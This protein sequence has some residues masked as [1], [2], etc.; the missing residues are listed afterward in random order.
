MDRNRVT[1]GMLLGLF[2]GSGCSAL[3]YE[4]VWFQQLSLVLG[5]SAVS[6]AILLSSFMGGMCLGSLFLPR[7]IP[8]NRHPLRVYALLEFLIA[9]CGVAVIWLMPVVGRLYCSLAGV[10]TGD[11]AL[12]S[13]VAI[14]MLLPPT[15]LMGATLPAMARWVATSRDGLS[16]L[17]LFYGANTFGAVLGSLLAGLYLLR[18][19]DV[20]VATYVAATINMV[21]AASAALMAR[22]VPFVAAAST[23]DFDGAER[24]TSRVRPVII[25]ITVGLSGMTALGAEV[26]WTRLLGLLLGPTA[27]TFSI[28]LA[29]FLLGLGIGSSVG[30]ALGRR[31]RSPGFALAVSQLLLMI[32]IPFAAFMIVSVLPFWLSSHGQHQSAWNRMSL[33]VVRA[34]AT[35]LPAACLWGASFPLAVAA[36]GD[37]RSDNGRLVGGISCANTLGAIAGAV[38]ASLFFIPMWGSHATQQLLTFVAGAA[39]VLML[40]TL[41]VST[42]YATTS[43]VNAEFGFSRRRLGLLT[44]LLTAVVCPFAPKLVRG[45]SNEL[46]AY[47]HSIE[48]WDSI[49][50]YLYVGEGIDS[51]IV[52]ATSSIGNRCFHI[53]GK[54]EATNSPSDMRTQRLL[55]HLP[56]LAHKSPRTVLV[57]GC[58]SGMTAGSFLLHPTVERV[59][60]CEM[61]SRVI[62]AVR[63]NF[64]RENYRVLDDPRTHVV[65]DD[66]RHF[67]A[68]TKE[69]FD[70]I[71]TDPIHPWVRGAAALYTAEFFELCNKH[72]NRGGVV[73]QWVPLY[74]S[75]E[76]AVKCELATFLHAFP[77]TTIWSGE[78]RQSGYDVI[79]VGSTDGIA[80]T[81]R[82]LLRKIVMNPAVA[83]SLTEIGIDNEAAVQRLLVAH[84]HDLTEWLRDADINRDRNLRLQYL[85]GLAPDGC[86]AQ[87]IIDNITRRRTPI[88]ETLS[89]SRDTTFR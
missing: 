62:D 44:L 56:A 57:V 21:V 54:V 81:P 85:A 11:L 48:L 14:G 55:G 19:Y 28:V 50:H 22:S 2:V 61:E 31:V 68:T 51:T 17:G 88:D 27:Y 26:V 47:G 59:V 58:G 52:V 66:A 49:D 10:G 67:L 41:M 89:D 70:V 69:T 20:L 25:G 78:T 35:L 15:I 16:R 53:S 12:R 60:I 82:D 76:P 72:L 5:A 30:A 7:V 64:A 86:L 74:E 6:L 42:R 45:V 75:S 23:G 83:Q 39:G 65:V 18:V 34:L 3:I 13:A 8:P 9:V 43:A 33:D 87:S 46:L 24:N 38:G 77:F 73:A 80:V 32:A 37:G 40:G 71:T 29:V 63:D 4:V 1:N 84:G 36:A 79:T